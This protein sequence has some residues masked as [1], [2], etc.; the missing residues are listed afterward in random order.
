MS[1]FVG[2]I[3]SLKPILVGARTAFVRGDMLPDILMSVLVNLV[4]LAAKPVGQT[5]APS[6]IVEKASTL[7]NRSTGNPGTE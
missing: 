6:E 7:A 5:I 4:Q 1:R 2:L 3:S